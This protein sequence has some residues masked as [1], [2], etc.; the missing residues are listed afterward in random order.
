M[1]KR[2]LCSEGQADPEYHQLRAQI[3]AAAASIHGLLSSCR[4]HML[5]QEAS[6]WRSKKLS[7]LLLKTL[8]SH[9]RS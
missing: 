8:D 3:E 2:Q 4:L 9:L 1:M 6:S 5:G 7:Y